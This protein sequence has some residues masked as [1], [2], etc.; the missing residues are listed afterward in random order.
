MRTICK[1][2]DYYEKNKNMKILFNKRN[3]FYS[4]LLTFKIAEII[5]IPA[6]TMEDAHVLTTQPLIHQVLHPEYIE[7]YAIASQKI[8]VPHTELSAN[9]SHI[10]LPTDEP[11]IELYID[12][13]HTELPTNIPTTQQPVNAPSGSLSPTANTSKKAQ[14]YFSSI[15]LPTLD[16]SF[17]S[18]FS[19]KSNSPTNLPQEQSSPKSVASPISEKK[20][21][22]SNI[23]DS[24]SSSLFGSKSNSP[25]NLSQEQSSPKSITSSTVENKIPINHPIAS[26]STSPLLSLSKNE[27]TPKIDTII[28]SWVNDNPG[29]TSNMY[30]QA[31]LEDDISNMI[32]TTNKTTKARELID[33]TTS[34]SKVKDALKS[35]LEKYKNDKNITAVLQTSLHT[36][37]TYQKS[38]TNI[39]KQTN[40]VITAFY[41]PEIKTTI[42]KMM[43]IKPEF[44]PI[45]GEIK[46]M[47]SIEM[48]KEEAEKNPTQATFNAVNAAIKA[49]QIAKYTITNDSSVTNNISYNPLTK[50]NITTQLETFDTQL[51]TSLANPLFD[52][53]KNVM[54]NHFLE[55][56]GL[57]D[58]TISS[59][60]DHLRSS[61]KTA[62]TTANQITE[63]K[64]D[65]L[66]NASGY[67]ASAIGGYARMGVPGAIIDTILYHVATENIP[68][69]MSKINT[70]TI[71]QLV[72]TITPSEKTLILNAHTTMN[73]M[74]SDK[75]TLQGELNKIIKGS[76]ADQIIQ[77]KTQ[78]NS[79]VANYYYQPKL[80]QAVFEFMNE[81]PQFDSTTGSIKNMPSIDT[82]LTKATNNPSQQAYKAL[83]ASLK[84]TNTA[85]YASQYDGSSL[86]ADNLYIKQLYVYKDQLTKTINSPQMIKYEKVVNRAAN[87]TKSLVPTTTDIINATGIMDKTVDTALNSPR[88]TKLVNLALNTTGLG[89]MTI[90]Q[91]I[92]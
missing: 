10:E 86:L 11:H 27:I 78:A 63:F 77:A 33:P 48:I 42:L 19:S 82:I 66:L 67:A 15:Q 16:L 53:Y 59:A 41:T 65:S 29:S 6:R 74:N 88:A 21:W 85:I 54:L 61:M 56:T 18:L 13:A 3:I 52:K 9:A 76:N 31:N 64:N 34:L 37:D 44:D 50:S 51:K 43:N 23:F 62:N 8:N 57:G 40:T 26:R 92:S 25:T 47:P 89:N 39:P 90:N 60:V 80:Q 24:A 75:I 55:N 49:M 87:Y 12:A 22:T 28:D 45:T 46:N 2:I 14:G 20:S 79:T 38:Q 5:S 69:M 68:S 17:E 1:A 4:M 84:A 72:D 7:N 71:A 35:L 36:I 70:M 58:L 91:A 81:Q 73:D 83:Q 30:V 32:F